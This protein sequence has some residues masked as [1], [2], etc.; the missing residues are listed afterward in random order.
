M[1]DFGLKRGCWLEN[2]KSGREVKMEGV[3]Y[4]ANRSLIRYTD[5]L[6]DSSIRQ[7]LLKQ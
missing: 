2:G 4:F 5:E 1:V 7:Y 6:L 3:I